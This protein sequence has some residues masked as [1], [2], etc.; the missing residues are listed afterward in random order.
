[1]LPPT[2]MLATKNRTRC[3]LVVFLLFAVFLA[4]CGPPGPRALLKGRKLLDRG[5]YAEAVVKL[6][7]ATSLMVTNA[8]AWNYLGVAEQRAGQTADAALAYQRALK[9]DRDLVRAHYNLGCLWLEQNRP[10]AA[11]TEFTAYTLRRGNTPEGW[12]KLGV[13]HLGLHDLASA[14]KSFSTAFSFDPHNAEALNGLGLA[15][16]QRGHPSEAAQYFA[17]AVRAHPDYEPALLN[18]ATVAQ[19]SLHDNPLALK[20]YRAYL[21]LSPH[22]ANWDEVNAIANDLEQQANATANPPLVNRQVS[23]ATP[24]AGEPKTQPPPAASR[25]QLA[26]AKPPAQPGTVA[27]ANPKPPYEPAPV[28]TV[29]VQPEPAIVGAQGP[30][31][32]AATK[33]SASAKSQPGQPGG[34]PGIMHELNPLN[35]FHSTPQEPKVTLLPPSNSNNHRVNPTPAPVASTPAVVAPAPAQPK[36]VHVVQPAPPSFPRY[37]YLSPSKPKPGNRQTAARAFAQA[38][39][40]EQ[41]EQ[42]SN[43]LDSY[44]EAARLDPGWFEAQYN[45]GVMAYRLRNYSQSLAACEMA[46]AIRSDS[47]DARY[48]FALALKAAGYVTDA[49][50]ELEKILASNPNDARAHL[51]L[52]NIYARQLHDLTQA[53]AHYLKV[54]Q[55]DPRNS[56][57][58]DIQFWLSANPP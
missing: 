23:S 31:T 53:R 7:T 39:Q 55:L 56:Q 51:T 22:R 17:A 42:F 6:K 26:S 41:E 37:L 21:A 48:N 27:H 58:T 24:G 43:A 9:L 36:P 16:I 8:Q 13:A 54:L 20:N 35:W 29:Q 11:K 52:G 2:P 57:A 28:E 49:M 12:V 10:D 14:E 4:G 5:D 34:K 25:T 50:N 32:S 1:M 30:S 44:R 46:L 45:C 19:Q 33:P 40:S 3:G 18:L 47:A 38:Q 15:Q